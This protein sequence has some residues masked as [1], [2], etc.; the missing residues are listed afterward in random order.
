MPLSDY[1]SRLTGTRFEPAGFTGDLR[2]PQATSV[3]D[4][5]FGRLALA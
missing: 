2:L 4:C 3:V 1:T 5:I